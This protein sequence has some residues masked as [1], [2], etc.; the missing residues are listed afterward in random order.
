M[1][2]NGSFITEP[3]LRDSYIHDVLSFE[4]VYTLKEMNDLETDSFLSE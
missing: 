4:I 1:H 3:L 2:K